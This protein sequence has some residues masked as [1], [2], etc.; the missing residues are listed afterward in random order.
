MENAGKMM[1]NKMVNPHRILASRTGSK[2]SNIHVTA[3]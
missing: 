3:S 2:V 1:W